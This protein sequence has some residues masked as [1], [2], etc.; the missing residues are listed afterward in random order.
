MGKKDD[1]NRSSGS[2]HTKA[3][4]GRLFR[5]NIRNKDDAS[6]QHVADRSPQNDP[7]GRTRQDGRHRG[8]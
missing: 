8:E 6:G 4:D 3:G 1:G 7:P 5:N 2:D